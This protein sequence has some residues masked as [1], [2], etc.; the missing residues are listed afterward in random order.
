MTGSRSSSGETPI[1]FQL[2]NFRAKNFVQRHDG[3]NRQGSPAS[4]RFPVR[5][6][7]AKLR[8]RP[9]RQDWRNGLEIWPGFIGQ[10]ATD[11]FERSIDA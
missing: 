7:R 6:N 4:N 9:K 3:K 5:D 11:V 1:R 2:W 8:E 10:D